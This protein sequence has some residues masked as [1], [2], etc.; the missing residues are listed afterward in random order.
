MIARDKPISVIVPVLH[1]GENIN[2]LR[3]HLRG[4]DGG[5]DVEIVIVEGARERDTLKALR[6]KDVKRVISP[7]GRGVQM[8]RGAEASRGEILLFLHA[9]TFLPDK[10]F[11]KI[12]ET[13][14]D[15]RIWAGAFSLRFYDAPFYMRIFQPLHDLRGLVTRVAFGDQGFFIRRGRFFEMGGFRELK[16]LEDLDMMVRLRRSGKKIRIRREKVRTSA[17]RYL[18]K[19]PIKNLSINIFLISAYY[20]GMDTDRYHDLYIK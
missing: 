11:I 8:N 17:R 19:G 18:E 6:A 2:I 16:V 7:M 13:L 14:D 12:R 10:A 3:D 1:E 15:E 9:D 4:L 5:R 20:L